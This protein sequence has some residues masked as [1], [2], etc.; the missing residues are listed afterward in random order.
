MRKIIQKFLR[1]F[2][3]K[4]KVFLECEYKAGI[5][6]ASKCNDITVYAFRG[7]QLTITNDEFK[8][9]TGPSDLWPETKQC[10]NKPTK[11]LQGSYAEPGSKAKPYCEE[12]YNKMVEALASYQ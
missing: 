2:K 12:C 4:K 9:S 7:N 3:R 5:D 11:Y 1:L 6:P 8:C 10:L